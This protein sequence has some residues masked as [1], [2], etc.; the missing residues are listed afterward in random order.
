MYQVI[1]IDGDDDAYRPILKFCSEADSRLR[2]VLWRGIG[3]LCSPVERVWTVVA[4]G[5]RVV[6]LYLALLLDAHAL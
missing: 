5:W 4:R 3:S 2:V 1:A 6:V